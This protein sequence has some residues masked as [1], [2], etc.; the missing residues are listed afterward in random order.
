MGRADGLLFGGAL[1]AGVMLGRPALLLVP[2]IVALLQLLSGNVAVPRIL[3]CAVLAGVGAFRA[4]ETSPVATLDQDLLSS[5][6]AVG[7]VSSVPTATDAGQ[8]FLLDVAAV[9][10]DDEWRAAPFTALLTLRGNDF[11]A[12][13]KVWVRWALSA[14]EDVS[15]SF[16][17]YLRSEG[18]VTTARVFA[19]E[20]QVKGTS[21]RRP[22]GDVRERVSAFLRGASHGD[23]GALLAGL[24]TGDD[25]SLSEGGALAFQRTGTT[26]ITAVSGSNLALVAGLWGALGT[27]AGWRRRWWLGA[28]IVGSV[29]IY[30]GVVGFEPPALRAAAVVSLTVYGLRI[31]RRPD[32]L[33]LVVVAAAAMAL[34][35]PAMVHSLS[36]QLSVVTSAALVS[37]LPRRS[38]AKLSVWFRGALT[39]VVCAQFAALP[40]LVAT[41]GVWTPLGVPAN[42]AILPL[43]SL[44]FTIA[45]FAALIGFA[46]PAV[47]TY[48]A[49]L[50]SFGAI[51]IVE[52]VEWMDRLAQPV[53][54]G[55]RNDL[56]V[57]LVTTLSVVTVGALSG[58][59]R[60]WL[61]DVPV[62]RVRHGILSPVA[63]ASFGGGALAGILAFLLFW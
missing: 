7:H 50:A 11:N 38:G 59:V 17:T 3:L 36:F 60:C 37:C 13:D 35:D 18:A 43:V 9:L 53:S 25:S 12:G 54:L 28:A 62:G 23:G 48:L 26:H 47:G 45:F 49:V 58:D 55:P 52:I 42:L 63:V 46:L 30:A 14:P 1:L 24:V 22:F 34:A 15:P 29:W 56:H 32:P 57:L 41:F 2:S 5:T 44:T 20:V 33:T 16:L 19:G 31:G 8:R 27:A 10:V 4:P 39:G 51:W 21:F 6:I 61:H 40:L